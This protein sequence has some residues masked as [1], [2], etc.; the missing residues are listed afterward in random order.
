MENK[1][2]FELE[3]KFTEA[4]KKHIECHPAIREV[5]CLKEMFSYVL[6]EVREDDVFAGRDIFGTVGFSPELTSYGYYCQDNIIK[7]ALLTMEMDETHRKKLEDVIDFWKEEALRVKVRNAYP[8]HLTNV[9]PS[10]NF[11]GEAGVAFPLYRMGGVYLNYDKLMKLGITGLMEEVRGCIE[12]ENL[13]N[14]NVELFKAMEMSLELIIEGCQRYALQARKLRKEDMALALENITQAPPKNLREAIQ[15]MWIYSIFS[16][17]LNFGRMDVYLGDF[18][19]QDIDSGLLSEQEALH[20]V[21]GLWKLIAERKTTWNGRV[22][23][24]GQGRKNEVNADRFAL[25]AMEATRQVKAIEPQLS[26]RFYEGMNSSLMEKALEIIGEGRTY[27]LLYNDDINVKAAEKAFEVSYEEAL[28]YVPFG[29]GEYVLDHRSFGTPSGV[30]NLLK[31]LEITLHNGKDPSTGRQLGIKTGN[32]ETLDSFEALFKAYKKQVTYFVDALAE[33][34]ELEYRVTGENAAFLY[35]SMLYDGCMEN[36]K[37]IFSGGIKYLGGTLETYGNTNTADSLTAIKEL[38]YDKKI[39]SKE[40]MLASLDNN[41]EGYEKERIAMLSVP[42]YGNDDDK[43]D[44][45]AMELHNFVCNAIKAAGKKTK[46]HSYMAVIIN[47]DANTT[48]G[49]W[50]MASA[51]GRKAHD[52]MANANMPSA[53]SDKKGITAMLNSIVKL[54]P[55]ILAGAV[56]NMKF[57]KDMFNKNRKTVKAL[58]N[59][60]FYKGGTQAMIT[61]VNRGDLENALVE[62]EKYSHIFVRVGGFSARF[63]ELAPAVQKEIISRTLY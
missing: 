7:E 42:K 35:L 23:I 34:E 22:I 4:Y 52:P 46:L 50:T 15:L 8:E 5:M 20:L 57:S 58:L 33:Q 12:R 30:I 51:D 9:L 62:P 43:A 31:V 6:C 45:M 27:P 18:Y 25:A 21:I 61:V 2:N 47:N 53:G 39:M 14:G 38:V 41:F 10:D 40:Q 13:K 28:Q 54:D 11:T 48:L 32:F 49:K 55:S 36:G 37:A 19:T 3:I 56:Q 29:C 59:T 60:Y 17:A 1:N 63:I 44:L 16:R 24:G 26:L